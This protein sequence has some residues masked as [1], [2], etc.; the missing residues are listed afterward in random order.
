MKALCPEFADNAATGGA[1]IP[2][3][4]SESGSSAAMILA[5]L[6]SHG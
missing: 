1:L 5:A 2:A 6:M 3:P 4:P